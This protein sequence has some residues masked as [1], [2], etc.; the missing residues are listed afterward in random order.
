MSCNRNTALCAKGNPVSYPIANPP[1]CSAPFTESYIQSTHWRYSNMKCA[2]FLEPD[3]GLKRTPS[4][5]FVTTMF[6]DRQFWM[7]K[8]SANSTKCNSTSPDVSI[9]GDSCSCY[10]VA[11][12]YPINPEGMLMYLN[13]QFTSHHLSASSKTKPSEQRIQMTTYIRRAGSN[14]NA[15]T[16]TQGS[17]VVVTVAQLLRVAG[18][19]LDEYADTAQSEPGVAL[20]GA[21]GGN[22]PFNRNTGVCLLLD[23]EYMNYDQSADANTGIKYTDHSDKVACIITI[24]RIGTWCSMGSEAVDYAESPRFTHETGSSNG[25]M[26]VQETHFLDR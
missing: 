24:S 18:V 1:Y 16:F 26:Y 10:D 9:V 23:M 6:H 7:T 21:P 3:M 11:N 25:N 2:R 4:Y 8:C 17:A 13:H 15:Y 14:D 19:E 22:Y 5:L 20:F 12:Y